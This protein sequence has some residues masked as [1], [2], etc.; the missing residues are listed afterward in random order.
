MQKILWLGEPYFAGALAACGWEKVAIHNPKTYDV[1]SWSELVALAGFTPD[2]LVVADS[3]TPPM[4]LG[5][6]SF[7][8]L[9]VF[10]SQDSHLHSWHSLYAQAF[11]AALV[12]MDDYLQRFNG[13]FLGKERIWWSPA[14][15]RDRHIPDPGAE[16]I[17]DCL[18]VGA[19]DEKLMPRRYAFLR[20]L[21]GLAPSLR[22]KNGDF[23][24][25]APQSRIIVNHA[26]SGNLNFRVFDAMGSGVCLVTPRVGHGLEKIF[27]DGE[28]MVGYTPEDAGDAAYRINFLLETPGLCEH[29]AAAGLAEIDAKHRAIHR[30]QAFTDNLCDLAMLDA[31][32]AIRSRRGMASSIRSQALSVLYLNWAN[33]T[34]V[35]HHKKAFACAA[36]G[37]FGLNGIQA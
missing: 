36:R 11:D 19:N 15:A 28:H 2:V 27:I 30:A 35:Q 4:A 10:Y 20:E 16:K 23:S 13:L 12:S 26:E 32:E 37:K 14:F 29:I 17:W 9:T 25:L 21:S 7:P 33:K 1:H 31:G 3:S 24:K 22:I 8:C 5:I 34:P 18:F 6:E